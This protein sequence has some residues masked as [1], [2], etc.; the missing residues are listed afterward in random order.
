MRAG[1]PI[2]SPSNTNTMNINTTLEAP[3]AVPSPV[4][5]TPNSAPYQAP[6]IESVLSPDDLQREV[7][8]AGTGG[9]ISDPDVPTFPGG[10]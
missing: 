4:A 10:F 3:H 6:A 8:Y 1:R 5:A 9:L 7:L 2:P